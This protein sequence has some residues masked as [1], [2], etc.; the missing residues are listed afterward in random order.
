MDIQI[1]NK[2]KTNI[3]TTHRLKKITNNVLKLVLEEKGRMNAEVSVVY[4]D[5]P[6]MKDLNKRFK[7]ISKPTDILSFPMNDGKLAGI[8]P[9]LLGD[10]VI[11]VPYARKQAIEH[12]HSLERELTVLLIHGL[13]H[14]MGYDHKTEKSEMLMKEQEMEC[15]LLVEEELSIA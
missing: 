9:N 8:N 2:C 4:M 3:I 12:S 6:E 15:M 5:E 1:R 14:L 11:C 13:L 10:I 7:K